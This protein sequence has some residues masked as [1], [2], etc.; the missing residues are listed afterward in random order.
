MR[1]TNLFRYYQRLI[2]FGIKQ[3]NLL[4]L[5]D[6]ADKFSTS[7]RHARTLLKQLQD[8][9][10]LVWQPSIGR[11]RRSVLHLHYSLEELQ[12]ILALQLVN[13]GDYTEAQQMLSGDKQRFGRLLQAT[14]GASQR[15]GLVHLQL[16]YYR[17]FS[18]LL[19]H[20]SQRNSERYFLRQIYSGL[21]QCDKS[22]KIRADLAHHWQHDDIKQIWRFYL[23]PGLTFHNGDCIE[24]TDVVTLFSQLKKRIDY[25]SE[26]AHVETIS[27][28]SPL[29]IEFKLSHPDNGF[30]GLLADP[31]YLIQPPQQL[32]DQTAQLP[33]GSGLFKV[34][35]H[36]NER[37]QL[38]AFDHYY[39]CRAL[40]EQVT[41]WHVTNEKDRQQTYTGCDLQLQQSTE[42]GNNLSPKLSSSC[43][44]SLVNS[45]DRNTETSTEHAGQE[46]L[47]SRVEYGCQYLIFNQ[48]R[49]E[50][51]LTLAQRRWLTDYLTPQKL[52][53]MSLENKDAMNV[54]IAKS[55]LPCWTGI[56]R[57]A[58]PQVSLPVQLDIAT[59]DQTELQQYAM[60]I[61]T[62]LAEL[63]VKC[64][65]SVYNYAELQ[66]RI[67][68]SEL[69]ETLILTSTNIG[70]NRP[71]STFRWLFSDPLLHGSFSSEASLWLTEQLTQ[72]RETRS[73]EEY[74]TALE[75]LVTTM[76]SEAWLHPLFHQRQRIRFQNI[77]KD[78]AMTGWGWPE[79]KNVWIEN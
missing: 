28:L 71:A 77:L 50:T 39:G 41:I 42:T 17:P 76:L 8:K 72:I 57:P 58:A 16:T 65:I 59:Y 3:D 6:I 11:Q 69:T 47:P 44:Y 34:R 25:A 66:Q 53:L 74:L 46:Q 48:N 30:P 21:V 55:L 20:L 49:K 18:P 13:Q 4:T 29:G 63:K 23:R 56:S 22:G 54:E 19:P 73:L 36:D 27:A 7:P 5:S 35:Q 14:S 62:L 68:Q 24:A 31:K 26:L 52:L 38:Q 37:L 51:R 33:I 60:L 32:L 75:P 67:Y 15:S 2:A 64:N 78:V 12:Q 45:A 70:D 40:P 61:Q 10:W 1:N 43:Q 79:L 9:D